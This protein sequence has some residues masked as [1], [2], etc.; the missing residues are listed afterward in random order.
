LFEQDKIKKILEKDWEEKKFEDKLKI[1][2][3]LP[4]KFYTNNKKSIITI[5]ID[6]NKKIFGLGSKF[7]PFERK[8][9][10]FDN[11]NTDNPYHAYFVDNLYSTLNIFYIFDEKTETTV[12][13]ILDYPGIIRY[14]FGK[15]CIN[16][17]RIE[18]SSTSFQLIKFKEKDFYSSVKKAYQICENFYKPPFH[19]FGYTYSHWGIKSLKEI[20]KITKSHE[21]E[22]IA[23][24]N[25]CLDIDYMDSFKNFTI[26]ENYGNFEGFENF[27]KKLKEKNT[28]LIPIIDAGIKVEEDYKAYEEFKNKGSLV[29]NKNGN[30]YFGNVWPGKS[31]FPDFFDVKDQLIFKNLMDDWI[32]KTDTNGCWLDM[33]EPSI[34]NE[35]SRTFSE[36][37]RFFDG[38]IENEK[39]HNMYP[40]FQA[41]AA[42]QCYI[43]NNIRPMMFSRSFYTFM[44]QYCGNWT[45][46]NQPR[47]FHLKTGFQQIISLSISLV[48]YCGTDIGG[49]WFNPT[50][51]LLV[52]WF[53]AC[54]FHPLYRNHSS[55][56]A[57]PREIPLLK[58]KVKEKIKSIINTRYALIPSIY[59]LFMISTFNKKPYIMPYI[60]KKDDKF[61]ISDK[62]IIISDTIVY[63]PFETDLLKDDFEFKKYKVFDWIDIYLKKGKGIFLT[64]KFQNSKNIFET[65]PLKFIGTFD[66][67]DTIVGEIYF[68]D[69]I[70]SFSLNN[71]AIYSFVVTKENNEMIKKSINKIF[72]NLEKNIESEIEKM[73]NEIDIQI[74]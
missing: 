9:R 29:K 17:I 68:D 42:Y 55:I 18:I 23:L 2:D 27:S 25:I 63:D 10:V 53:K 15:T 52:K 61:N 19:A 6:N 40:Y 41:K 72:S 33:N 38:K 69:G 71:F 28:F 3:N 73:L 24:T 20:E 57:K 4:I 16:Q 12:C 59:S 51:D 1:E 66:E 49:F 32:K 46:D 37:A 62:V 65:F 64:S 14:D 50:N 45:G 8:G 70:S 7:A 48:M 43:A 26:N 11:L 44:N 58:T 60:Y 36:D 21:E 13:F 56:F 67:N 54:L 39:L 30:F 5:S 22:N 47:F 31:V 74:I 35:K 34:F